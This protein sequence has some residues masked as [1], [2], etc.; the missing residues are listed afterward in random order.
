MY[1]LVIQLQFVTAEQWQTGL[2]AYIE[3]PKKYYFTD[4]GLRNARINFRRFEQT[5]TME[6]VI[7]KELC[8]RG[9]SVDIGVIPIME[10]DKNGK[11]K[12]KQLEVDFICNMGSV[13]Y[14]NQS[15]YLHPTEGKN[16]QEIRP[17]R[18]IDDSFRKIIITKDMVPAYYDEHG[19]LTVNIYD[20]LLDRDSINKLGE[21]E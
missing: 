21:R 7:Y 20:F 8:M 16:N 9:Y 18:E 11:M 1:G 10:K 19:I 4:L 17:L 15:A 14:Y 13:R 12:H 2:R 5:H 6:N 3:I